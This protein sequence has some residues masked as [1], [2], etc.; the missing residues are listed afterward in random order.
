MSFAAGAA[1]HV[2][3][4][5]KGTVREVRNRGRYLVD[6]GARSVVTTEDQLTAIDGPAKSRTVRVPQRPGY[7]PPSDASPSLDLHGHTVDEAMEVLVTF[8]NDAIL[9]GAAE[10]RVIHGRSGGRIKAAVHRQLGQI[11]TVRTYRVDAAN[12]GVTIVKL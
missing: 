8:I 6:L 2:K 1:V 5:G 3:G 11:A 12:A 9:R 7:D 4:L 10:V